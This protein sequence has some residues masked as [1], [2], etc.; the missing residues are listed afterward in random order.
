MVPSG[1][2]KSGRRSGVVSP[3]AIALDDIVDERVSVGFL[4]GV[5]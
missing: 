2:P 4:A 1:L 5:E 3:S